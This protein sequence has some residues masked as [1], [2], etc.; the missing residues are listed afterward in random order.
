MEDP[1]KELMQL[2]LYP[3]RF[4]G[5]KLG[6]DTDPLIL[7]YI[8]AAVLT[9]LSLLLRILGFRRLSKLVGVLA[10]LSTVSPLLFTIYSLLSLLQLI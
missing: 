1:V 3:Y 4:I 2:L 10:L 8:I 6:L 5:D 7:A 9:A